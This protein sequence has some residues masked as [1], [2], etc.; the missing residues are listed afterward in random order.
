M[1]ARRVAVL[2]DR[3]LRGAAAPIEVDHERRGRALGGRGGV[4][5]A[6]DRVAGAEDRPELTGLRELA[7][8]LPRL[9]AELPRARND[10]PQAGRKH[11]ALLVRGVE[12]ALQLARPTGELEQPVGELT[13]PVPQPRYAAGQDF[14]TGFEAPLPAQQLVDAAPQRHCP[15]LEA[16]RSV[17][18]LHEPGQKGPELGGDRP[19][20][21]RGLVRPR[22]G[23]CELGVETVVA[24]LN[25]LAGRGVP[26]GNRA[27]R[28]VRGP[29]RAYP[30]RVRLAG[31]Q[32][33]VE[34]GD[35]LPEL[36]VRDLHGLTQ[37]LEPVGA[38]IELRGERP[39][40]GQS[41][42]Q[43]V[44]RLL[45]AP[46]QRAGPAGRLARPAAQGLGARDRQLEPG[47]QVARAGERAARAEPQRHGA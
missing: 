15:A 17:A 44:G 28:S 33:C 47:A 42:A 25:R 39:H 22:A 11:P 3:E 46:R 21:V 41:R 10:L 29:V 23:L 1:R 19:R 4:E 14:G 20:A 24:R 13:A 6:E 45:E 34:R 9:V 27:E 30:L 40:P 5:R 12:P 16:Q 37:P 38:G 8:R 26:P 36:R 7:A 35:G 43:A 32:H 2:H 18:E 31:R